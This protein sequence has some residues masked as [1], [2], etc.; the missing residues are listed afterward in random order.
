MRE[1]A[2]SRVPL[3][4][5]WRLPWVVGASSL[6][7]PIAYALTTSLVVS[8]DA[9]ERG[10]TTVG[11]SCWIRAWL[12]APCPSC[13]LTRA[14]AAMGHG[15]IDRA[16]AY[17]R[18]APALYVAYWLIGLAALA[19]VVT[20]LAR[21]NRVGHARAKETIDAAALWT[22]PRGRASWIRLRWSPGSR[23]RRAAWRGRASWAR[24][25]WSP[26]SRLR[27]VLWARLRGSS[28]GGTGG[29]A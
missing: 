14:F 7:L 23:L 4:E 6:L 8:P 10:E 19:V 28:R 18:L 21:W 22:S 24:L 27:R 5:N 11:P 16:I 17:H 25:R 20:H 9:I 15:D 1:A 2:A 29:A 26:G 3:L 13:G 12:G